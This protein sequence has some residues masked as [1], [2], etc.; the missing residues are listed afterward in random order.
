[1][2]VALSLLTHMPFSGI[3]D[4]KVQSENGRTRERVDTGE[5]LHLFL[6]KH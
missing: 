2:H 1:M 4:G 6:Q 5:T 3:P